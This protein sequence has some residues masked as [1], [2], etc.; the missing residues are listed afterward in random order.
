[1]KPSGVLL[2]LLNEIA[3][4]GIGAIYC[5]SD[6]ILISVTVSDGSLLAAISAIH[7]NFNLLFL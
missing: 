3:V 6:G 4:Y 5:T 1:M 7:G 2:L